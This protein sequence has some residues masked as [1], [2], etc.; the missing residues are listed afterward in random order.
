MRNVLVQKGQ[1]ATAVVL[2][3]LQLGADLASRFSLPGHLDG[4][5]TP[6]WMTRYAFIRGRRF[7]QRIVALHVA[8][9]ALVPW[10]AGTGF[11]THDWWDVTVHVV[12]LDRAVAGGMA[13][14]A[15]RIHDHLRGLAEQ[16]AGKRLRIC[17]V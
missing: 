5:H 4:S 3:I 1:I 10:T 15:A 17:N 12:A 8:R 16:R 7:Q 9:H 2:G 14:H 6:S 13:V 11:A